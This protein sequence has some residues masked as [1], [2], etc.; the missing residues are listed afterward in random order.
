[1][2]L[3]RLHRAGLRFHLLVILVL[4]ILLVLLPPRSDAQALAGELDLSAAEGRVDACQA[5]LVA[6]NDTCTCDAG[7]TWQSNGTH[8][9]CA[10]C[11]AGSYK[12][13]PGLHACSACPALMTSFEG[14]AEAVDCLC[15]RTLLT[16]SVQSMPK[17]H[18]ATLLFS[19]VWRISASFLSL[20][21]ASAFGCR[22]RLR[23]N[24]VTRTGLL[25]AGFGFL[26]NVVTRGSWPR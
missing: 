23:L 16:R 9:A 15:A 22:S 14:A 8:Q 24:H 10:P 19:T 3:Y 6:F 13:G 17:W 4:L 26:T 1:M 2:L 20:R 11:A 21:I 12:P 7:A 5:P 18:G 25:A